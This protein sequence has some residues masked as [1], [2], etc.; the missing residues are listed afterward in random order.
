[1]VRD[2]VRIRFRKA[3]DLRLVSHHD[4]MRCF[5]RMLRRAELPVHRTEGF[6]PKPR[7]VFALSLGLG[8]VGQEE[9][10]ELELDAELPPEEVRDRLARQTPAGLDIL[11]VERIDPKQG[12]QV[13]RVSYRI[14]F[15]AQQPNDVPER[16]ASFLAS[17]EAWAER[18]RPSPRRINLRP[19]VEDL[20]ILPDSL[21][22]DLIV[23]PGGTARPDELLRLLGLGD[24]LAS[25]AVLERTKLELHDESSHLE[26]VKGKA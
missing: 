12:A 10:A 4:L 19:Y 14:A 3:G 9:V 5:E 15:P 2:K 1:M 11:S 6:H 22:M 23:T 20:R 25:G 8:I 26:T 13:R 17:T 21:E 7:L 16:V 18:T 24:L